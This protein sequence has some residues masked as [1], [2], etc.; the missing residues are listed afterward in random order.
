MAVLSPSQAAKIASGVYQ[1]RT[2]SVDDLMAS[3][4]ELNPLG[5]EGIFGQSSRFTG[6][7]GAVFRPLSG[8]GYVAN[9]VGEFAGDMLIATRGTAN[10]ADWLTDFN[11]SLQRGP[12]GER[13]HAGFNETWRSFAPAL[14]DALKGH[15]PTR[16]HCVGHSL[17]GGLAFLN[18]DFLTA[19]RVADVRVYTFGAPRTGLD[20]FGRQLTQRVGA[21]NFFRVSHPSDPVPMIPL[22]PFFHV[23]F[24]EE[25]LAIAKGSSL[26]VNPWAHFMSPSYISGV[27]N[28]SWENLKVKKP[29]DRTIQSWI[30]AGGF[31]ATLGS[32]KYLELIGL[33]MNKL[34]R[35][36]GMVLKG[37]LGLAGIGIVTVLDTLSCM[38]SQA[39]QV[40]AEMGR[41]VQMLIG[42]IFK[43]LGRTAVT[44]AQLTAAFLRWVLDLMFNAVR[45]VAVRA[46]SMIR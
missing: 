22:W 45:N 7:S 21:G 14:R 25:G 35:D 24:D 36:A 1:L 26:A 46:L 13:V 44:G 20:A 19:N 38:L 41:G 33:V 10:G 6:T 30:D 39:A 9:G 11:V 28:K 43:F 8:F 23:P 32:G 27:A 37:S 18:A 15:N 31:S 5:I 42:M 34:L 40:S 29:D 17:G 2:K 4:G 3:V 12:S 16:I